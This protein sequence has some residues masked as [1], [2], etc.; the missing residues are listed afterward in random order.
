MNPTLCSKAMHSQAVARTSRSKVV[1]GLRPAVAIL[2]VL[3][4]SLASVA[5]AA[6]LRKLDPELNRRA[7]VASGRSS[8]VVVRLA[9]GASLPGSLQKYVRGAKLQLIDGYVLSIPDSALAALE[10]LPQVESAHQDRPAWAADYLS[11]RATGANVVQQS[12]DLTGRGIGVAV[13]DSGI[14]SW[15]DD[16]TAGDSRTYPYADQRVSKFVDFVSGQT[17]PYDDH[18]HGS[19]V[20]GI[21]LGNGYDSHGRQAG[22]AP[23]A[24]LVSLK[25][26]DAEGKGTISR[27]IAALD[28]VAANARTY[29]IRVVNL[30]VGAA[31]TQSYWIDPL[32]L[33]ARRLT[34]RGIVV[35][36]AAGNLGQNAD[37]GRQYGGIVAPGNAPW[38]L[39]VGA[40]STE[41][42]TRAQDDVVAAFSSLGPTRGDY[43]AKPDLVAP[44]RGVLS[45][46]VPGST[47]YQANASYLVSG[48]VK[49]GSPAYLSLSGT[50]MA[51]PQVS[52][53]VA[54]MLQANPRLTPNLVKAILQYTARADSSY[55]ALQQGAGFLDV[56]GAVRLSRFYAQNRAGSRLPVERTWSQQ[57]VWGNQLISG[58][59]INPL[60]NAW[61]TNIVWGTA[62]TTADNIVWGT[63]GSAENIVWGTLCG[64]ANCANIVWGT[65]DAS[66]ANIVWGTADNIVWGTT[67]ADNIV[68]GTA[69][70]AEN[71]VWGTSGP[72]ENIV[73]GTACGGDNCANIVWGTTTADN[74]V[75]GT[76]GPNENI[77]WGT[78]DN[79]VWGTF[80]ENGNIVWGTAGEA[81]NIVW[82][83]ADNGNIVWGTA[84][85]ANIVWGTATTADNIV[86]GT[87]DNIVWGT[88]DAS[89]IVWG[90]AD[91]DNIVWGAAAVGPN[92]N[93]R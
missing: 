4:L 78:A 82:G 43:L 35:V 56:G 17:M 37:G 3:V 69:G 39:T 45:L 87:A 2:A 53:A 58:G 91:V 79:I 88:A 54:L 38:V 75:W 85:N 46:A 33:A 52:G 55:G 86:W 67:T 41:G 9:P 15:H 49:T 84:D 29:N 77:V 64:D 50:S 24:S 92:G 80:T 31:V 48:G 10:A 12:L 40:S 90:T 11:T 1:W 83:T 74:I 34:E 63:A 72:S 51:A 59:Y 62:Y 65:A 18:G 71:I 28:W 20:A 70:S 36:A 61:A 5:H 22:I 6:G 76:V 7:A 73:W 42:T 30:S 21:I 81:G 57:I 68:W 19:H 26:L 16:L 60:A 47:L 8:Q 13:V 44:G 14:T 27:I 66:G 89:N 93:G 23:D 32:A 25:V